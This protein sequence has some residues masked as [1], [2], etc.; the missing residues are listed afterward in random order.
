MTDTVAPSIT[1]TADELFVAPYLAPSNAYDEAFDGRGSVRLPWQAIT[2]AMQQLGAEGMQDR[3]LR[4]QRILRD[5]GATY[6]LKSDPLSPNV[7]S[8]DII[9]NVMMKA[10]W[11]KLESALQQRAKL[12]DLL[13]KDLYGEQRLLK[14]GVI[15]SEI[16]FS[17]PGFLRQCHD[18]PWPS[19][20]RLT[21]HAVDLVRDQSGRFIATGDRTQAPSGAGYALENRTVVSRILPSLFRDSRTMRLSGFFQTVRETISQLAAHITESPRI[22]VL[23][24]GAYSS[25]YFEQAF[26]ANHLGYPLVQGG[27]LTV[28]NGKVWMKSLDG[29]SRVD[30][31]LRRV[32]D[33]FCDQAELRSDSGLG[34]PGLLE[35]ARQGNVIVT[36]PLGSGLLET[37]ALLAFLPDIAQCLMGEELLLPSVDSYWC[38]NA[39]QL[40]YVLNNLPQLIIKPAFRSQLSKS[41][42]G[43]QLD[44]QGLA[45]ITAAILE[46]PIA[47][48]AQTYIPGSHSPIWEDGAL[49]SRPCILRT[50]S[51]ASDEGYRVMPGGL[52][53]VAD[54]RDQTIVSKNL[55]GSRSKDMWIL[56]DT[57]EADIDVPLDNLPGAQAEA[58]NLPSRVIENLFWFGRYAE[59]AEMSLRLMRTIFKQ[60]NGI[61]IF[62]T[63]SRKVLLC[64]MSD[65][66]GSLPGFHDQ[67]ELLENPNDELAALVVDSQRMGSIKSNLQQML[68]CAE[69]VK[70]MLSADTRIILNELRDHIH[71]IDRA[72]INGLPPVPEESLDSLVTS[73]LAISGLNH[74]SMLRGMDWMFQ[75]IG[76]RTERAMLTAN[77]L[78]N[79]L[80][81]PLP[82]LQQ[83]QVL[84]S[85]LLSVEALISFRRRYRTRA[86]VSYGLDLLM[87]DRSNP[88]SLIYQVEQLRKYVSELP[89]TD[90]G[91]LG[92]SPENRFII[93][94]L[95]DIQ[96]A[97][98]DSLA[99]IDETS[100]TRHNLTELM[101]Q[102]MDNLE[103]L[104]TILSDKYFD[105]TAGP[106]QLVKAKWKNNV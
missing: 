17:H 29:L 75:E 21:F 94:S 16:I 13:Y 100:Q 14:E 67:P 44:K 32:E 62:P 56:S 69:Q 101:T 88:R 70:E 9:P 18:M 37:P 50:F 19:E 15:P 52:A 104:T 58:A 59:R 34:V 71:S 46:N 93:K 8:L 83:Q 80:S 39:K 10:E 102:V 33:A 7:W 105:H 98:L 68:A 96:L 84:E 22:V 66:S 11:L 78:K 60:L 91:T 85:V 36:N 40:D 103:H 25:T 86:R 43:H 89:T 5:D 92:L 41:V 76:R 63:E 64:A 73:L 26:L 12:F 35:V 45:D 28:R 3:H 74:E 106:Q 51:V 79:T 72:Y 49:S 24:P 54:S 20:H 65:I 82:S 77:L 87:I 4:A 2:T 23:T 6:N 47:Y 55:S 97:D 99:Q 90:Q 81:E 95:N 42:Y 53:R 38:G 31:I 57:V 48:V 1:T 27:D 30:V 61:D